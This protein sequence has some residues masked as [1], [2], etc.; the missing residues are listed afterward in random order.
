MSNK[1]ASDFI[2]QLSLNPTLQRELASDLVGA[3]DPS[4]GLSRIVGFAA[5]R[6]YDVTPEELALLVHNENELNDE[7]LSGV[8]GGVVAVPAFVAQE[9]ARTADYQIL[10]S[11]LKTI[12]EQA[13]IFNK[14]ML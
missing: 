12:N 3:S 7:Q 1:A 14:T 6:G 10:I 8:V 4:E 5:E 13:G 9:Q 11:M 2:A